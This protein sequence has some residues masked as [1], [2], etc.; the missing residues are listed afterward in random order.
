MVS[1]NLI[2]AFILAIELVINVVPLSAMIFGS[3]SATKVIPAG[4]VQCREIGTF[5]IGSYV[6]G[7]RFLFQHLVNI[8]PN[9][10]SKLGGIMTHVEIIKSK[11]GEIITRLELNSWLRTESTGE[12]IQVTDMSSDHTSITIKFWSKPREAI[13]FT[14][15]VDGYNPNE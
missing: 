11:N 15:Y 12:R 10:R 1:C 13:N 4:Q 7:Q 2:Y 3:S 8:K 5:L 9:M 14:I 6:P